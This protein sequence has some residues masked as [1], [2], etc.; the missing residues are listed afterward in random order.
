VHAKQAGLIADTFL[1]GLA[2]DAQRIAELK[3]GYEAWLPEVLREF[4]LWVDPL[5]AWPAEEAFWRAEAIA[6]RAAS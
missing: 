6:E 5:I 3:A 2:G 1:A 4:S